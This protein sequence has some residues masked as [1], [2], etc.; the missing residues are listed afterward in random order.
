MT[1]SPAAFAERFWLRRA[2]FALL[3]LTTIGA[4][5]GAFAWLIGRD[6]LDLLDWL[7][8]ACLALTLPWTIIGFWNAVIGLAILYLKRDPVGYVT[9]MV[10]DG[11]GDRPLVGRTALLMAIHDEDPEAVFRHL[12]ATVESL[13]RAGAGDA[14]DIFELSDTRD[15]AIAEE[16]VR[17][18]EAWQRVDP[19]PERLRY[20]RRAVNTD[21]KTG[22]IWDWLDNQGD[23]YAYFVTLDADSLMSGRML[24]RLVRIMD[25]N[26]DLGILQTLVVGL[27][28]A[29]AF[30]RIFQFGMRHG[31]RSYTTGSAWWLGDAGPYWGCLLY[32]S[33]SPRDHG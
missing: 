24:S 10:R 5:F 9:P 18:F 8:L 13:D 17:V 26:P 29:S 33:P 15:A 23:A 20:R 27:P 7:M 19:R 6:G 25:K 28:S 4:A 31:M 30:A 12:R 21:H 14:Y 2:A 3:V 16:E 32:T 1:T 11:D 22:N